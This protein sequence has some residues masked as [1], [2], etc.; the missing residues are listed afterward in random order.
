MRNDYLMC[1]TN[2]DEL[3]SRRATG[4]GPVPITPTADAP[5]PAQTDAVGPSAPQHR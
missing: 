4:P 1:I 3:R 2:R 5:A